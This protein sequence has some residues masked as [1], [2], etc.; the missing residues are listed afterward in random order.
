MTA[1]DPD[2]WKH[3]WNRRGD[4]RLRVL[5]NRMY[6]QERQRI[7]DL[8][9]GLVKVIALL[10]GSTALAKVANPEVVQWCAVAITASSAASLV[11]GF[12]AKSRDSAKRSAE[13]ALLERDIESRGERGFSED[14]LN[15]WAARCNEIEAAEPAAHPGLLERCNLRACEVM[16]SKP[17]TKA[18]F[19]RRYRPA[20]F[21]H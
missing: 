15:S 13:W 9:E 12:G 10:A 3:L 8:R 6:Y 16:G 19:W 5:M 14:D 2:L 17:V 11:F 18:S 1:I 7:F 4:I 21:I 20:I